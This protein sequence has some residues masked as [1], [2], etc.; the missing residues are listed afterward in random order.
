MSRITECKLLEDAESFNELE[1]ELTLANIS[2]LDLVKFV[3]HGGKLL[4]D[5]GVLQVE[6]VLWD[7]GALHASYISETFLDANFESLSPYV[8][9]SKSHIKMASGA[10]RI[11]ITR[12]L[13]LPTSFAD[14]SGIE[15]T[16][17]I[18]FFV[19]PES[20]NELIIGLPAIIVHFGKIF[21]ERI[22]SAIGSCGVS[23]SLQHIATGD[24]DLRTPWTV[25][26]EEEAPEEAPLPC[27]FTDALHFMEMTPEEAKEEYLSQFTEHVSPE[28][29]ANTGVLDLLKTKGHRVFV[30][31]NWEGIR[32][33]P[34]LELNWKP[35]LPERMKPK[36]R[37]VN[38]RLYEAAKKEFDRLLG[39]FYQ[40]SDSSVASCLVIAPKATK[41]F[42]R[43]CG[44]YV[45]INRYII[46][47]HYPIPHVQRSL[48]KIRLFDI[49]MDLDLVNSFHQF[50]LAFQTS[51]N[52]SVQTPWGQVAPI[53]MPE[54]VSPAT[55]V[56]QENA[57]KIFAGFEDWS[58]ILFD[59]IL[60]LAHD[61][62]D[63]YSKLDKILDRCIEYNLYL[64]FSK[65]WLG[66]T[67]VH[68]FGY[69]CVHNS[70]SISPDRQKALSEYPP[71][72]SQKAMQSFLG[73]ALYFKSFVP[74]Y[75]SLAAPL[76]E[77]TKSDQVWNPL[78]WTPARTE[79]FANFKKALLASFALYYPD[80]NLP[81]ILRTDASKEGVGIALFQVHRPT[82]ESA[83]EYQV[84]LFASQKFSPQARKWTTIEQEAYGI[85]YG[86]K[87]CSYYLRCKDFVL[88]TDH[89]NLQWMEASEVPKVIRW[90]IYL[91]S[92][93][94]SLRHIPGKQ[95]IVADWLS[96]SFSEESLSALLADDP[97][98][99]SCLCLLM[100]SID[101][102]QHSLAPVTRSAAASATPDA[103]QQES[104]PSTPEEYFSK[105]HGGRMGHFGAR[106]TWRALNQHYPG[107][108]VPFRVIEELV[109]N[110]G[111]CQ[112]DRLGMVDTLEPIYRTLKPSTKR[113]RVGADG[114]TIT[115]KDKNGN[116]YA[117][118][119][120]V[121]ATKL[122]GIYPSVDKSALST[123]LALF[124]FFSTYGVFEELVTDPGSD[125]TSEVVAHLTGWFGIRHKFSLVD[126]HES[127]GVE[128]TNKQIVRHTKALC[129]DERVADRW[130][131]PPVICLV[132]YVLNSQVH[133]E[134][135]MV[136][137]HAHFGSDDYTYLRLPE[138]SSATETAHEFV[139]LL[140]ADLRALWQASQKFQQSIVSK[141]SA[142]DVPSQQNQ[143]QPGDLVLFRRDPSQ[144]LPTKLTLRYKGPYEVLSQYKNDVECKHLCMR[145]IEVFHVERLKLYSGTREEAERI[146]LLDY[147]QYEV[148]TILKYRGNPEIRTTMEFFIKYKDGEERWVTWSY[149][150][151]NSIPYEEFC[152]KH[153]ALY[154]L[155]FT[156]DEADRRRRELNATPITEVS[157]GT[158]I[159]L[160]LRQR[161]GAAWYNSIGLPR[162]DELTYVLPCTYIS[163]VNNTHKKIRLSCP[164]TNERLL[165]DHWLVKTYGNCQVFDQANMVLIDPALCAQYPKITDG[166]A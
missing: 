63:A 45:A 95:N 103:D 108:R 142:N 26:I 57:T 3:Y 79:A 155:L 18:K 75:S 87:Q 25:P 85:Y 162:S 120:V 149:D 116:S 113:K 86:V 136:P 52:L 67:K 160:D 104:A 19:L 50:K 140:D 77:M 80:Y 23:H 53:F 27:S 59:N 94:F 36:A 159:F 105:V 141:R 51:Q 82:P 117:T 1:I 8:Q 158:E 110:C 132:N 123:A 147:D 122:V 90:R 41:P 15:H 44:D 91:Q 153:S 150:L 22:K 81:W 37:P 164:V 60:I 73:A 109:S 137:H 146:A 10:Q 129:A 84:I 154:P 32:N 112:K 68:F 39:Y 107:H 148:E 62:A 157:P 115:P 139:K 71:P 106:R 134:T 35:D 48:E 101:S 163:W 69:D 28:F 56:L 92:F 99:L 102:E 143:Y 161:G 88:E 152:R 130:S 128:G 156:K 66:F 54:G 4:L 72:Q 31:Q 166:N 58:I 11:P 40:P 133:H 21:V 47:G 96:R 144:P 98:L 24:D 20:D 6:N 126:R 65:S 30:P 121:E 111:I 61:Y 2:A 17:N 42:I 16:A 9:Y 38:P 49:F 70:Y 127:N 78:I 34:P 46:T 13:I 33:I 43:F 12:H 118:I 151:F 138:A 55:F 76:H 131:D 145:N 125:L 100:H 119:V 89:A 7:T 14:Y 97:T 74:H 93:H 29:A 135:G 165:M 114:L 64:K 83:P 5:N 124:Q